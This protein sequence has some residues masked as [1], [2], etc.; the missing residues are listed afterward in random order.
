M[1]VKMNEGTNPS[2]NKNVPEYI[3]PQ[4]TQTSSDLLSK[5]RVFPELKSSY[6]YKYLK[7]RDGKP[8]I[9]DMFISQVVNKVLKET[10]V[11][12]GKIEW[13]YDLSD[14]KQTLK[15]TFKWDSGNQGRVFSKTYKFNISN[16][17]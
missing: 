6:F 1:A 3:A 9:S 12:D 7:M 17:V 10:Q 5:F 16:G 4:T 2:N 11:S 13:A 14:D 8:Y 15:L